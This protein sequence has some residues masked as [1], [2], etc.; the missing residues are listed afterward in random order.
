MG[1]SEP[2]QEPD[3]AGVAAPALPCPVCG[4]SRTPGSLRCPTCESLYSWTAT[5]RACGAPVPE[6][7]GVCHECG[8]HP[9]SIGRW[10]RFVRSGQGVLSLLIALFSV[11]GTLVALLSQATCFHESSTRVTFSAFP[12]P[13]SPGK[14]PQL[15]VRVVAYNSG[16]SPSLITAA[17]V[18]TK[19][20]GRWH[21]AGLTTEPVKVESH[22]LQL[23]TLQLD[24]GWDIQT[25]FGIANRTDPRYEGLLG[26]RHQ[27]QVQVQEFNET[28]RWK[29]VQQVRQEDLRAWL[30]VVTTDSPDST[31]G[32]G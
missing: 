27:L 16:N 22:D 19:Y 20:E 31:G 18:K 26:L 24:G 17:R 12:P 32:G 6:D 9:D 3:G 2:T 1:D 4:E 7:A 15:D 29:P 8:L 25:L 5:C 13:P 21:S 23:V 30:R 11:A 28:P 10:G 14:N